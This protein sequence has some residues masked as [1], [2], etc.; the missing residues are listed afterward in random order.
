MPLSLYTTQKSHIWSLS[1][2][3]LAIIV[4]RERNILMHHRNNLNFFHLIQIFNQIVFCYQTELCT[5]LLFTV[6]N[7]FFTR[8]FTFFQS[9][10]TKRE[11]RKA[12]TQ[13]F[14]PGHFPVLRKSPRCFRI[15]LFSSSDQGFLAVRL[16]IWLFPAI[17]KSN[18][19]GIILYA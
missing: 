13:S 11:S 4:L 10:L 16:H 12:R 6:D 5:N 15:A 18:T 19:F 3:Y 14:F 7:I 1:Q 17:N 2:I 9:R 8:Y